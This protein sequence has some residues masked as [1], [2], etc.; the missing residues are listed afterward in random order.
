MAKGILIFINHEH[1][2]GKDKAEY[3]LLSLDGVKPKNLNKT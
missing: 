2:M 3:V 1:Q